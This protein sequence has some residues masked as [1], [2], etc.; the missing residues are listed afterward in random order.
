MR[1]LFINHHANSPKY[2]NP[3]RTYYMARELVSLGHEVFIVAANNS[4]LRT[5]Q[6]QQSSQLVSE[7][8]DGINYMFLPSFPSSKSIFTRLLNMLTFVIMLARYQKHIQ[9]ITRPDYVIEATTYIAPF[10]IS[11]RIAKNSKAKVIYE[12]RDLWP[13]SPIE[14]SGRSR[15][16]PIF[17]IIGLLQK[18]TLKNADCVISTLKYADE[19]FTTNVI[20]PKLFAHIQNGISMRQYSGSF[21]KKSFYYDEVA[22]IKEKYDGCIGYTGGLGAANGLDVL[23]GSAD[24]LEKHNLAIII[25]GKGINREKYLSYQK[26]NVY[27]FDAIPKE[28]IIQVS[29]LFDLG[30]VGGVNR[31]VHRYG[32][33]A[34][35]IF[36]MM[37]SK[38]PVLFCYNTQDSFIEDAQCGII[39]NDP[40]S[41][42]VADEI[43]TFFKMPKTERK[44]MGENGYRTALE[45]YEYATLTLKLLNAIRVIQ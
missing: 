29:K 42:R 3:Y 26:P 28:E 20:K 36:D 6:P 10:L 18:Y 7:K 15:F 17:F 31:K 13:A 23:L 5:S 1:F 8:I 24:E 22:Q 2:G 16:N 30:F 27:I 14:I 25:F 9:N 12:V 11:Y 37:A 39:I 41:D 19:Y 35:K 21:M 43:I 34:N 33:S 4:H 44:A 32:V 40:T 45:K 38:V